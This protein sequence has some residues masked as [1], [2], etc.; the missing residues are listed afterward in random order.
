MILHF[1]N[2]T[3]ESL[4]DHTVDERGISG[5]SEKGVREGKLLL[6]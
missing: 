3:S 1:E 2:K 4:L 5:T 6:K